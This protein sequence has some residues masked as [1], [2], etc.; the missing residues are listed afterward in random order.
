MPNFFPCEFSLFGK[1]KSKRKGKIKPVISL[2]DVRFLDFTF[3]SFPFKC[4]PIHF[5]LPSCFPQIN[6]SIRHQLDS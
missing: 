1:K 4:K 6:L 3:S 2:L 5:A